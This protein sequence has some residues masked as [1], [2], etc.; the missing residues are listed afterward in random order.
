MVEILCPHCDE[1]IALDDDAE[2]EF[3]CPYCDGEFEWV[4]E[5]TNEAEQIDSQDYGG[6]SNAA[7]TIREMI[8]RGMFGSFFLAGIVM[9]IVGIA[10]ISISASLW[11]TI[12]DSP[13]SDTLGAGWGTVIILGLVAIGFLLSISLGFYGLSIVLFGLARF[14]NKKN[15]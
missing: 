14:S 1:E 2:G 10:G 13:S 3:E 9:V 8:S 7:S 6:Y 15:I 12:T 5:S 4:V 11:G